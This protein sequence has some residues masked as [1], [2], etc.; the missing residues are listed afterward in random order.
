MLMAMKRPL[1]IPKLK[2]AQTSQSTTFQKNMTSPIMTEGNWPLTCIQK[3]TDVDHM[4]KMWLMKTIGQGRGITE[5]MAIVL[6]GH[7][8]ILPEFL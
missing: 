4:L 3:S 8:H 5:L 6:L 1:M 2:T 7:T